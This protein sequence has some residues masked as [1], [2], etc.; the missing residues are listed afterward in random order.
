MY[1][2]IMLINGPNLN[3][4]GVRQPEIYG[5]DTLKDIE[6][7]VKNEAEKNA[8][9]LTM[10]MITEKHVPTQDEVDALLQKHGENSVEYN[11]NHTYDNQANCADKNNIIQNL[12]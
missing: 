12:C 4:L 5:T 8:L 3:M 2:K 9:T 6:N 7:L 10:F 1:N 11:R